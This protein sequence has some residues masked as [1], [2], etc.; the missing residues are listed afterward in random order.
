MTWPPRDLQNRPGW[1]D[2]TT[3]RPFQIK[4]YSQSFPFVPKQFCNVSNSPFYLFVAIFAKQPS[5]NK[6]LLILRG[7]GGGGGGVSGISMT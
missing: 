7:G 5:F 1:R 4:K 2:Q 6:H 3:S